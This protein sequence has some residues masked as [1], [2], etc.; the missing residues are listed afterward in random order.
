MTALAG[1]LIFFL[2]KLMIALV[3]LFVVGTLVFSI[4][5]IMPGDPVM[6]LLGSEGSA[7]PEAI[8]AMRQKLGLDQPILQ[9]Y[10]SWLGGVLRFDLG[11]SVLGGYSVSK[12]V[13]DNL[14]RTLELGFAAIIIASLIGIPV[15]MAAALNRGRFL[16]T[17]LTSVTTFGISVPVYI[18]GAFLI[19]IFSLQLGWLPSSG[20]MDISRNMPEH[21]RR[22]I[23]P[24]FTLGFGLAASIARMTRSSMLE[25]LNRDFIR[26]LRAKGMS[27]RRII[28]Q[29][30]L[31]NA[32]I[33]I[34]T[35]IGLQLG[36][37][38]GGT[39]LVEAMFNWPGLSTLLVDAVGSRDYPVVQ[40]SVL[41]IAAMFI[42]INLAV[43]LL[44]GA[45]DPRIRRRR[46]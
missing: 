21:F 16:D 25:I 12:L 38:M 22:L 35:I 18:L 3:Q 6:L 15:G 30:A 2:R 26:A 45:L 4:M 10:A 27:E 13:L 8:A 23:L 1:F 42:F 40:G 5:F 33:P 32:S 46:A 43:E 19:I 31:R 14:P 20:Y 9:Q 29:H 11:N 28:W 41:A 39:V 17:A 37:M 7:T 34:V 44:Y 36:N 24:A